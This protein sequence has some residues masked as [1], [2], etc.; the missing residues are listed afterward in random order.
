MITRNSLLA[1]G[2]LILAACGGGS[3]GQVG[4]LGTSEAAVREFMAA[5]QDSNIQRMG[6]AWGGSSGPAASTNDPSDWEKRLRVVQVYLRGGTFRLTSDTPMGGDA[7]RRSIQVELTRGSCVRTIPFVAVRS[8]NGWLV[9]SVD[10]S[11]AGNPR[12]PCP[13]PGATQ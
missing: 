1:C 9:E 2:A 3:T 12:N 8:G 6:R 5:V 11:A 13:A 4:P 7:S 10:I